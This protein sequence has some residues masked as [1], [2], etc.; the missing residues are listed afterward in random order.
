MNASKQA[1]DGPIGI[2]MLDTAFERFVGDI[3]NPSTWPFNVEYKIVK[4]ATPAT[5]L[6]LDE[7]QTYQQFEAAADSLIERGAIGISTTCGFLGLYQKTL[8]EH[9]SVPVATSALLQVPMVERLLPV[10]KRVGILTYNAQALSTKHLDAL[11]V[12][13]DTPIAGIAEDSLFFRWIM[14][15]IPD[16]KPE[17]LLPDVL[18][19]AKQ[20]LA[21]HP[22]VGAIVLECTNL[23]PYAKAVTAT[24]GLPVYDMVS[25]MHWFHNGL[26]PRY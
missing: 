3:G 23:T 13:H 21:D 19:A 1:F 5:A 18:A 24:T 26:K 2:L 10:N 25:L 12:R 4:G 7:D 16:I 14:Q 20:L 11:G 17:Q 15:G 22:E 9:C 6:Q 8:A